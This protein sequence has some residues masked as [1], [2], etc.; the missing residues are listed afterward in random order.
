MFG[1]A[2]TFSTASISGRPSVGTTVSGSASILLGGSNDVFT[3]GEP[4]WEHD[5]LSAA[6]FSHI[7]EQNWRAFFRWSNVDKVYAFLYEQLRFAAQTLARP[8]AWLEQH[9]LQGI[10]IISAAMICGGFWMG[11]VSAVSSGLT[12]TPMPPLL[13]GAICIA[14]VSL[15]SCRPYRPCFRN[16][17]GPSSCCS[18]CGL[19]RDG[20]RC[21]GRDSGGCACLASRPRLR[22]PSELPHSSSGD[23]QAAARRVRT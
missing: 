18:L 3:G 1:G 20:I 15:R 10:L 12:I 17:P 8:V 23:G 22:N 14:A 13:I 4:L 21:A 5:R 6:D 7:F 16:S 2:G 19:S 9:G 11:K